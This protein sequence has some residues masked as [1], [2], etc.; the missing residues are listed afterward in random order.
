MFRYACNRNHVHK[1]PD[2]VLGSVKLL[3]LEVLLPSQDNVAINFTE[4]WERLLKSDLKTDLLLLLFLDSVILI[5]FSIK[6]YF[7]NKVLFLAKGV[8]CWMWSMMSSWGK[9]TDVR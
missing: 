5:T 2:Y 8:F 1:D 9:M 7:I 4:N 3:I 6:E